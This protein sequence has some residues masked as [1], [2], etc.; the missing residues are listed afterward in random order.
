VAIAPSFGNP[1]QMQT[2]VQVMGTVVEVLLIPIKWVT[3]P[4]SKKRSEKPSGQ[5]EPET[6]KGW[7]QISVFLGEPVSVVKRWAAEGM[8]LHR[9]SQFVGTSPD[10]LNAWLGKESG[11]PVH[12]A[13]ENTDLTAELKRAL[14]F[15]R[16][17]KTGQPQEKTIGTIWEGKEITYFRNSALFH[18][19]D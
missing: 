17:E 5:R 9:K 13:T 10:E 11:K 12:V 2:L 4:R 3:M 19:S 7:K 6:L 8:P 15:V 18:S 16:S 14:S 1:R